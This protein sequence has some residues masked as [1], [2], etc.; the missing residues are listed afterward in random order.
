MSLLDKPS[1][2][3]LSRSLDAAAL[4][5]KVVANNIA[6]VDTPK[7]KRSD[8]VFEELL[9]NEMSSPR[10]IVGSRSDRRHFYI[11]SGSQSGPQIQTD[12]RAVMNNNLNNVDIDSEM[13]LLAKNQLRY[14]VMVQEVNHDIK[15]MRTAINGGK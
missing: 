7:F 3:L 6:N 12:E 9:Q 8:V 2:N 5:Q 13:S 15:M 10:G 11:S 14:N 1:F 4:R